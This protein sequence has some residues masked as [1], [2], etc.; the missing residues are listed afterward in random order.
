VNADAE[1]R[2]PKRTVPGHVLVQ[3]QFPSGFVLSFTCSSVCARGPAPTF[4]GHKGSIQVGASGDKLDLVREEAFS[5][6]TDAVRIEGLKGD[7]PLG[8]LKNWFDCIRSG[9]K[10]NGDID[11]ALKVQTLIS[12][13]EMSDR[14]KV[15]CLFDAQTRKVKDGTGREIALLTHGMLD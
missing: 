10:P 6:Q 14:L 7:D 4:Y 8:H 3:A 2:M 15:T 12:L 1:A 5:S 13:A 9:G 11:L